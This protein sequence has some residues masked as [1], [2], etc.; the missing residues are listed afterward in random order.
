M[1]RSERPWV[2]AQLGRPVWEGGEATEPGKSFPSLL[3]RRFFLFLL[4][5]RAG[6]AGEVLV[7]FAILSYSILILILNL[8]FYLV[9]YRPTEVIGDRANADL[10]GQNVFP[11]TDEDVGQ[12]VPDVTARSGV[13]PSWFV[14]CGV[15]VRVGAEL[16]IQGTD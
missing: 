7:L 3:S 16:C 2:F 5:A 4:K 11:H 14:R 1:N 13:A 9:H 15:I 12:V 8:P 6:P 10:R